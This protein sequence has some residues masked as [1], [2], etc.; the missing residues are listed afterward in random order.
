MWWTGPVVP[1]EDRDV[2]L[3]HV[4]GHIL[5]RVQGLELLGEAGQAHACTP[6]YRLGLVC[7][8]VPARR[9]CLRTQGNVGG[10]YV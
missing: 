8:G 2:V 7:L 6:L 3:K 1:E 9:R 10:F 5:N 4:E